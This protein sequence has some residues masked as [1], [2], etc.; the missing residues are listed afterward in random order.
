MFHPGRG[1]GE[2][3]SAKAKL[4]YATLADIPNWRKILSNFYN[5]PFSLDGKKWHSVEHFYHASK[6]KKGH[7]EF[8]STFALDSGSE[9]SK[10]ANLAKVAG[11]KTGITEV[12][13]KGGKSRK[14]RMRPVDI[15]ID[16]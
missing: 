9:L 6:F 4:K 13:R 15:L 10:K 14:L 11:G 16:S 8:Y 1:S 3:I 7:P 12:K 2:K 5:A